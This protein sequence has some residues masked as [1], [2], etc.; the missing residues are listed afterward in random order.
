M[1]FG[2][3]ISRTYRIIIIISVGFG[4]FVITETGSLQGLV[5]TSLGI[6]VT[7]FFVLK[8][9][10][11][12]KLINYGYVSVF[13]F[14]AVLAIMGTLQK[15]PLTSVLYKTSVSL[16]GEYWQAGI[17]MGLSRPLTGV[18]LDSYGTYYRVF[19]N[20][21]AIILPG[22]NT[23]T[24]TAHN[25]FID[26]FAA[27]G[28]VGLLS[29]LTLMFTVFLYAIKTFREQRNY[30]PVFTAIFVGWIAY[31][32]QSIISI[33][34]IGLAIWG[35]LLSGA[36]VAYSKL[37]VDVNVE[38]K[39]EKLKFRL[40][41]S[42]SKK[43]IEYDV[44]AG[45]LMRLYSAILIGLLMAIPPFIADVQLRQA[46]KS[47]DK[48]KLFAV[49]TKWPMDSTRTNYVLTRA[50]PE[51]A[52]VTEPMIKLAV[53][54]GK[55][56]PVDYATAYAIYQLSADGSDQRISYKAKLHRLDPLN[57]EFAPK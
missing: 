15:G 49:A 17:N 11:E 3:N 29:Y 28:V 43:K 47:N 55:K 52:E 10:Y 18:G 57:P 33:N 46:L 21:S 51:G 4:I 25:V 24:D 31:Q 2:R 13:T 54:A 5:V 20:E 26:I 45:E 32:A 50:L 34:Q 48:E 30:D 35:W 27:T 22:V 19:R 53:I 16:R 9:R 6:L 23:V 38:V 44:P 8:F 42:K 36:I 40:S 12:S 39:N 37:R 41:K 7:L 56:F 14:A 1:F